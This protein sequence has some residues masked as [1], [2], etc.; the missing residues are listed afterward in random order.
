MPQRG[1][2]SVPGGFVETG[3]TLE[4]AASRETME[5]TG[6][7]LNPS[8]LQPCFL[9]SLPHINE[10]Y[11]GFR[12]RLAIRPHLRRGPE[13]LEVAMYQESDLLNEQLAF[14]SVL[15]DYYR[16]F[17]C[18]LRS[19][20]FPVVS[21]RFTPVEVSS[22]SAATPKARAAVKGV[23]VMSSSARRSCGPSTRR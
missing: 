1:M 13:S 16:R 15:T 21:M 17:F 8:Q 22:D 5:E 19:A 4:E 7:E 20:Q 2:W 11:V 10:V 6:V 14:G 12:A 3:E 9:A 23:G 18:Q